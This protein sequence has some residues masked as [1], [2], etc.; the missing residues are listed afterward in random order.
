M[1]VLCRAFP[2]LTYLSM[3]RNPACPNLYFSD[4]EA[5][6]YMRYRLYVI[7]RMPGLELLDSTPVTEEEADEARRVGKFLR[8][9]RPDAAAEEQRRPRGKGKKAGAGSTADAVAPAKEEPLAKPAAFL[10]RA[11][12]RYDG[13]HS[14]GNR[15]ITDSEL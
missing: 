3:L 7:H 4:G 5:E 13:T 14:E 1:D 15:F 2:A 6:A 11:P 12:R 10:A 8:V 9:A